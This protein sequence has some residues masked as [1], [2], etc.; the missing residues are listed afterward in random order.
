MEITRTKKPHPASF[1]LPGKHSYY[2]CSSILTPVK[3]N[4]VL[5]V[6][7]L[8][9]KNHNTLLEPTI[10]NEHRFQ[11]RQHFM[12]LRIRSTGELNQTLMSESLCTMM[13]ILNPKKNCHPE[14][15]HSPIG[16]S[17]S[18]IQ[19]RAKI[20]GT[21]RYHFPLRSRQAKSALCRSSGAS[22]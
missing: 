17:K 15:C 1:L 9:S 21:S 19:F 12:F 2:R 13:R 7:A 8:L 22:Q 10:A 5:G 11:D 4:G 6:A 20:R 16:Q 18:N 14:L 3:Q